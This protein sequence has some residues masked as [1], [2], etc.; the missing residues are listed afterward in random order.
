MTKVATTFAELVTNKNREN[1]IT[2][3]KSSYLA[4]NVCYFIASYDRISST[5]TGKLLVQSERK[6]MCFV[7]KH[8]NL[9]ITCTFLPSSSPWTGCF[10]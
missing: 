7:V 10:N 9:R 8:V 3:C 2:R 6:I 5:P 4:P 1:F